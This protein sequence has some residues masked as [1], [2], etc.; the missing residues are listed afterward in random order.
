MKILI[1]DD[2]SFMRMI[3]KKYLEGFKDVQ[4]IEGANGKEAVEKFR[5]EHP[6]LIFLDIIMP[7]INGIEAL[8]QIK[9]FDR[10]ANVVMISSVGQNK[11]MEEAIK[12]GAARYI[13]KPFRYEEIVE[14]VNQFK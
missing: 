3:I 5:S 7:E 11:M 1:V 13:T 10:N 14:V 12:A 4:V 9:S 8:K 6:D 2:S